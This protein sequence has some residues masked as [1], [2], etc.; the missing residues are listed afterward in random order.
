MIEL[1]AT[2][3]PING[4]NALAITGG[5]ASELKQAFDL[6][7]AKVDDAQN[8]RVI[9]PEKT[10]NAG[11]AVGPQREL[12]A[13]AKRMNIEATSDFREVEGGGNATEE[14]VV[15]RTKS[16]ALLGSQDTTYLQ[17]T[18]V[19][20]LDD[21]PSQTPEMKLPHAEVA[22][23]SL[24][25]EGRIEPR[26]AAMEP[27][28]AP[29]QSTEL[30]APPVARNEDISSASELGADAE[31]ALSALIA[32]APAS[33]VEELGMPM[34]ADQEAFRES[35][36]VSAPPS[37][38]DLSFVQV[39]L[40]AT[41]GPKG[42]DVL[43]Q[44]TVALPA[45]NDA[46]TREM[47][48]AIPTVREGGSQFV[49][50]HLNT[51]KVKPIDRAYAPSE[52]KGPLAISPAALLRS[53]DL[54][55]IKGEPIGRNFEQLTPRPLNADGTSRGKVSA[56]AP[57]QHTVPAVGVVSGVVPDSP[58][59]GVTGQ[60]PVLL[61]LA[62]NQGGID[63]APAATD[64]LA[65]ISI[66]E[67]S[68]ATSKG[69]TLQGSPA[70]AGEPT[71]LPSSAPVLSLTSGYAKLTSPSIDSKPTHATE[72][73]V[74]QANSG[75][76]PVASAKVLELGQTMSVGH[77]L[78]ALDLDQNANSLRSPPLT[79]DMP[80]GR[81][82]TVQTAVRQNDP[83]LDH[84][85]KRAQEP[86]S[87]ASRAPENVAVSSVTETDRTYDVRD[88]VPHTT[89]GGMHTFGGTPVAVAQFAPMLE[90]SA[91]EKVRAEGDI[92]IAASFSSELKTHTTGAVD[93]LGRGPATPVPQEVLKIA[94]QLRAG[95][96]MDRYPLEIA[97]DPPELGQ[98]RMVLQ[99]S[100]AT[101]TLLIIADRPETAEL[102]RRHANFLH[103]AFAQEGKGGLNL[104]FGT[105]SDGQQ[106]VANGGGASGRGAQQ[107]SQAE[108]DIGSL[109]ETSVMTP[110]PNS[111]SS[112]GLNLTL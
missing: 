43:H 26:L 80:S 72:V 12:G 33:E 25:L 111:S 63:V 96:R 98:V 30:A 27:S 28:L 76:V 64:R 39:S 55:S 81:A 112:S 73:P 7:L 31:V 10:P 105:P 101:T 2:P 70:E 38:F 84:V 34:V 24:V 99:T 93:T 60:A 94:E 110:R 3:P 14:D 65:A 18:Q 32:A 4:R 1:N 46:P 50:I 66:A 107:N 82:Q 68:T 22:R 87:T 11:A 90:Q 19:L 108:A 100:D 92:S 52:T 23:R 77:T 97:L 85:M 57:R 48:E 9:A 109:P 58:Y 5:V 71:N 21:R 102:M 47:S 74:K 59:I 89:T 8:V 29:N 95:V 15:G 83:V 40:S 78:S 67:T 88:L 53:S 104:Q 106:G 86:A 6:A 41:S 17:P 103:E 62:D 61:G 54:D 75:S 42:T 69:Y 35:F 51:E 13:T 16:M 44:K 20:G 91:H 37:R 36:A 79:P 49:P 45:V 56:E